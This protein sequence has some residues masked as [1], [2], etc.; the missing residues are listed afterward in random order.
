MVDI[1][2]GGSMERYLTQTLNTL[3]IPHEIYGY[4]IGVADYYTKNVKEFPLRMKGY[5]FDFKN[6]NDATD[7]RSSFVGLFESLFLEQ[8]GSVENYRYDDNGKIVSNRYPYEY[9]D[10]GRPTFEL[11][12]VKKIQKGALEFIKD[13]KQY[14]VLSNL[15]QINAN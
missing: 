3:N 14:N 15:L 10:D 6:D 8:D 5:L 13:V 12:S 4:Y 1:G 7:K 9:L 2:W 11:L